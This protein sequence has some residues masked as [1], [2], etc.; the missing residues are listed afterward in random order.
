MARFRSHGK[1][2]LTGEYLVLHGATALAV[3]CKLGQTLD[4]QPS[5]G[6]TVRWNS[7]DENGQSWF[8]VHFDIRTLKLF[9]T[10]EVE[11]W[12]KLSQILQKAKNLNPEFLSVG[13][14][15]TT[16]L[17]FDRS[18]G[19]GS[20]STLISNIAL[21]AQI[22]PY[23][24]L[25]QTFGGSGYDVACAQANTPILYTRNHFQPKIKSV[26]F[27]PSFKESL[28][29]V[30]LNQKKNSQEAIASFEPNLIRSSTITEMNK[31]TQS[32]LECNEQENFNRLLNSHEALLGAVLNQ[33]PV[34]EKLFEDFS[35]AI[36]SLGAWGGDFILA[37]GNHE[38]PAYFKRKGYPIVIPFEKMIT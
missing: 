16:Q 2:L 21:W 20:S 19:L 33:K 5:A 23:E 1:L 14:S 22:N 12:E 17:E 35:G 25:N 24:L 30:Y 27:N 38:S 32:F 28:F 3:P 15:V 13:G 7:L 10:N 26:P 6:Q 9:E 37:S 4:F 31:L 34:Q 36:K 11:I 29:F 8:E 18:W